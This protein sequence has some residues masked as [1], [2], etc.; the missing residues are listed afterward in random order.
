MPHHFT[1]HSPE[2]ALMLTKK[3]FDAL[4][5][6]EEGLALKNFVMHPSV[7][8]D[9]RF[10]ELR[11]VMG[12][13][14]VARRMAHTIP[15]PQPARSR[16]WQI[17]GTISSAAAC[18]ALVAGI[19]IYTYRQNNV[20]VA[21]IGGKRT[22]DRTLVMEAMRRSTNEM[23]IES[24]SPSMETQLNDMFSTLDSPQPEPND[25]SNHSLTSQP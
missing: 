19:S 1:I 4:T 24:A 21:Y 25:N 17:V 20:C 9:T 16:M 18:V 15:S 22:T 2:E 3:Y 6:E 5:S 11:A 12:V 7:A 10:D 14:V 8:A 13:A 23:H